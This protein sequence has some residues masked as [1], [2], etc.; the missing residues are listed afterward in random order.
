VATA[1]AYVAS[2]A[3]AALYLRGEVGLSLSL[4]SSR[5]PLNDIDLSTSTDFEDGLV[6]AVDSVF[7][8]EQDASV[9]ADGTSFYA[10]RSGETG[11]SRADLAAR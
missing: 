7:L 9:W 3:L 5:N 8:A 10:W 2:M 11:A 6:V 4:P 1:L